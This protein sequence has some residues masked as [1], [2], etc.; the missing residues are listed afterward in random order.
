MGFTERRD[1]IRKIEQQRGSTVICYLT[2]LRP[3]VAGMIAG[4]QVRVFFDHL[5]RFPKRPIEK[6]DIFLC[7]NGGDG[8]VPWRLVALFRE[9]ATKFN[10]LIPYRAYS[11]A[12]L[13]ALGADE[14]VMHPFAELGPIDPT[15]ANEFNPEDPV[16]RQKRAI[17]VE[18]V[19]AYVHFIKETVGITHEDELVRAIEILAQQVHPIALGNIER[20]ISQSRMIA[21]K[22][23]RTHM[24]D[25]ESHVIDEIVE[26]LASKLYFHGHPI[27]RKEAK[28][29]LK[30]KVK[31]DL[32]DNLE[33]WMWALYRDFEVEFQNADPFNPA[34][35]LA[36]AAANPQPAPAQPPPGQPGPGLPGQVIAGQPP[37]FID[38]ELL[39]AVIESTEMS[40][41]YLSK[42]RYARMQIVMPPQPI[43][44]V[45]IQDEMLEAGW[46]HLMAPAAPTRGQ[47]SSSAPAGTPSGG[48]VSRQ[49]RARSIRPRPEST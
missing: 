39:H 5:L 32:G 10:V 20:F 48:A 47:P 13:L 41:R 34:L 16:T 44:Q 33:K 4:D 1:I 21:R 28:E 31:V 27:N 19:T 45:A 15:V 9:F 17:S 2:T 11:A 14:I 35:E 22:I 42:H 18:D 49:R 6:L 36:A 26:N 37:G 24:A 40:S 43:P 38:R 12:S 7:S 25:T 46:S 3:G 29:E 8:T 30:L 23:L